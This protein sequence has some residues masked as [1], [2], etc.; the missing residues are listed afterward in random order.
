MPHIQE[1][2]SSSWRFDE[3]LDS[4]PGAKEPSLKRKRGFFPYTEDND[5][6]TLSVF[7]LGVFPSSSTA[8]ETFE[9][10]IPWYRWKRKSFAAPDER[11]KAFTVPTSDL[12][13]ED[14]FWDAQEPDFMLG[15]P[16]AADDD[17][18]RISPTT[19]VNGRILC[20]GVKDPK[21]V[22]EAKTFSSLPRV[23]KFELKINS[24][25]DR[26]LTWTDRV[27]RECG[28][29]KRG[30]YCVYQPR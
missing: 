15:L 23:S 27:T 30:I 2:R 19:N 12:E 20:G 14:E 4:S 21:I 22:E 13:S 29:L 24:G 25:L 28:N 6:D 17:D 9:D 10:S 3:S 26:I 7:E 1:E 16:V 11:A 5:D 8:L 18:S